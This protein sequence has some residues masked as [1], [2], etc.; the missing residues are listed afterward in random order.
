MKLFLCANCSDVLKM[1]KVD[2]RFC[3]CRESSARY[4]ADGDF[5]EISGK[6]IPIGI[7]NKSIIK[8]VAHRNFGGTD[9]SKLDLEAFVFSSNYYK[10]KKV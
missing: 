4:L 7:T 3:Q 10:I 5:A 6:A 2:W 1:T 8:A 9:F